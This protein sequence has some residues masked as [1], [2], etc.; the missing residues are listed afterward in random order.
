MDVVGSAAFSSLDIRNRRLND[1]AAADAFHD[2]DTMSRINDENKKLGTNVLRGIWSDTRNIGTFETPSAGHPDSEDVF[3]AQILQMSQDDLKKKLR[4]PGATGSFTIL[5]SGDQQI[6]YEWQTT[7]VAKKEGT[8]YE[9]KTSSKDLYEAIVG[10]KTETSLYFM[11]DAISVNFFDALIQDVGATQKYAFY[12]NTRERLNDAAGDRDLSK[13]SEN[14]KTKT[15]RLD[16]IEDEYEHRTTYTAMNATS[17]DPSNLFNSIYTLTLEGQK[18]SKTKEGLSAAILTFKKQNAGVVR[19]V[20]SQA[21]TLEGENSVNTLYKRI[22]NFFK[23][24]S[25]TDKEKEEYWVALQQKRSGDWLQVLSTFDTKRFQAVPTGEPIYLAS[26][27]RLC[28]AYGLCVGA[29]MI[30]THQV[31][32][33]GE[34]VITTF[35]RKAVKKVDPKT[36]LREEVLKYTGS[37]TISLEDAPLVPEG[38]KYI[39][40]IK[41]YLAFIEGKILALQSRIP[42]PSESALGELRAARFTPAMFDGILAAMFK[43]LYDLILVLRT[44]PFKAS[45]MA[46]VK[47]TAKEVKR[48]SLV[49]MRAKIHVF[50]ENVLA[51][52]DLLALSP[53]AFKTKESLQKALEGTYEL[54]DKS[55]PASEKYAPLGEFQMR[56]P[57]YSQFAMGFLAQ[58]E[59][60]MLPSLA[61]KVTRVLDAVEQTTLAAIQTKPDLARTIRMN[62]VLIKY[63]LCRD[64]KNFPVE[65]IPSFTELIQNTY[66]KPAAERKGNSFAVHRILARAYQNFVEA[67]KRNELI[68]EFYAEFQKRLA[69]ANAQR[70]GARSVRTSTTRRRSAVAKSRRISPRRDKKALLEAIEEI[71]DSSLKTASLVRT[72]SRERGATYTPTMSSVI[73]LYLVSLFIEDIRLDVETTY[74]APA[75]YLYG[76][77]LHAMNPEVFKGYGRAIGDLTSQTTFRFYWEVLGYFVFCILPN[78]TDH[79]TDDMKRALL[80]NVFPVHLSDLEEFARTIRKSVLGDGFDYSL[81][82]ERLDEFMTW[83]CFYRFLP[84]LKVGSGSLSKASIASDGFMAALKTYE[85]KVV[86]APS[87][88]RTAARK[89]MKRISLTKTKRRSQGRTKSAGLMDSE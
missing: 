11:I 19:S 87:A 36:R 59:P 26:M 34:Y 23:S 46:D 40:A 12:I 69:A 58:M 33:N 63:L 41:V 35:R 79:A 75:K 66:A 44:F 62:A 39:D 71:A 32:G 29:N 37:D 76:L 5:S 14:S 31:S 9:Y 27:D 81:G 86:S 56:I 85:T 73:P 52:R 60:Y 77:L 61:E 54:F 68:R 18:T 21:G 4:Q 24:R 74:T 1:L 65:S 47:L 70:A 8:S 28:I 82:E 88:A 10:N 22:A 64:V 80:S 6:Q 16:V 30:Y 42:W 89:T 67:R 45:F 57:I 38:I 17:K 72:R 48:K 3:F 50:Q 78:V 84:I 2:F 49:E 25:K 20:T 51:L 7:L 83:F 43:G 15:I 13:Y 53:E 55:N